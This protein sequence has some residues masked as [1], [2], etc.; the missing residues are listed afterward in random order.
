M[1]KFKNTISYKCSTWNVYTNVTKLGSKH[2]C[3]IINL[4][5]D[6]KFRIV[7]RAASGAKLHWGGIRYQCCIPP[8]R[9]LLVQFTS[10]SFL[11]RW[12]CTGVRDALHVWAPYRPRSSPSLLL[13][14]QET[15]M[16][17]QVTVQVQVHPRCRRL[18]LPAGACMN[19]HP[20]HTYR[21]F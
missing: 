4:A 8:G 21:P 6:R 17:T 11:W 2:V 12:P 16:G 5:L 9:R 20:L 15:T 14:G 7:V 19:E 13:R 3:F 10:I 1:C 18:Q